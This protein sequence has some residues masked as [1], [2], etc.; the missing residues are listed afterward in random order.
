MKVTMLSLLLAAPL[1]GQSGR[2]PPNWTNPFPPHRVIANI[3]YV[4]SEDLASYL[5]TTPA[6]HILIN[7]N[8]EESVPQIRAGVEKLG[9]RFSDIKILLGSHAHLDHMAGHALIKKLTGA[10]VLVMQGDEG[11]IRS[12]GQGDFQYNS[13]W[14]ACPVDRVL[15][16]G[17]EVKL[18]G[19]TLIARHTPGHTRGCTTWTTAVNENGR[20]YNVV[21]VGSPNVNAGYRLVENA[22]YPEIAEDYAHSFN[23]WK[24]LPCDV[25]L[26]AHGGYYGLA[27]KYRR[28]QE[29]PGVNAFIDPEGYRAYIAERERAY[30]QELE[31][32]RER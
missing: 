10:Q 26:G 19:F 20:S 5:I 13:H 29:N 4:G 12:G 25:F 9:F 15:H 11:I 3:Y 27:A 18:G 6:G 22:K 31:R 24:S 16:D 28:N 30:L 17:D 8:L 21:I 7:S 2:Y 23:I 32:Q 1:L 14:T